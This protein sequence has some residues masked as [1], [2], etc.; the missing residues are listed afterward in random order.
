M[1]LELNGDRLIILPDT[2]EQKTESGIVLARHPGQKDKGRIAIQRGLVLEV[3]PGRVTEQGER[4]APKVKPGDYVWYNLMLGVEFRWR[5][6]NGVDAT[7][8]ICEEGDLFG[9][10]AD[11]EWEFPA[12]MKP[13]GQALVS[14][15][16]LA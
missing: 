1:R 7:L 3:G 6:V 2:T 9:V 8:L 15:R 13:L 10:E 14:A 16:V 12:E 5:D 4:I 11:G